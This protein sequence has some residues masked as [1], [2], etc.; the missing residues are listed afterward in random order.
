VDVQGFS[1]DGRGI[2]RWR[3]KTLFVSGA[4]PGETVLCKQSAS[5]GRFNEA[6]TLSVIQASSE[7]VDAPCEFYQR[8]G[9]CDL[10]HLAVDKQLIRKQESVL[11]QLQRLGGLQPE[12]ILP[13]L[14]SESQDYRVRARLAVQWTK[15]GE[16]SLGFR[17]EGS[18]QVVPISQC[19]VLHP[20]ID[21]LLRPLREWLLSI[22]RN[23][24]VTHIELSADVEG[25][26]ILV[27]HTRKLEQVDRD[28]LNILAEKY[29]AVVDLQA[30]NDGV[31]LDLQGATVDP[32]RHYGLPE[33]ELN[34]SFHPS[35]FIQV[36]PELN[37]KM[38]GQ[39]LDLLNLEASD[40]VV[41]LF[42]G[43]GN[44]TL[45]IARRAASVIG[46]EAQ[47]TM[48]ARGRENAAANGMDNA[49][50][51]AANL[52]KPMAPGLLGKGKVDAILL[53]PPRSGAAGAM[54]FIA[55]L[56]PSKLVY[57]S[58]NPSTLARDA[59]ILVEHGYRF[60]TLGIMDMFPH[61]SH[62]ESMALFLLE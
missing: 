3:E 34:L 46:I 15:A 17:G 53:D 23:R 37:K 22:E 21:Q 12:K 60:D 20:S 44:F 42:C 57:V 49:T 31:L 24:P 2:G 47:E 32:R 16:P 56:K 10:Q 25:A 29:S 4:L 33:F 58:C 27:R 62:V 36:N 61:T 55:Q 39:A 52:E 59:K 18:K 7:R 28:S 48:V 40:K 13:A 50:F 51:V 19:T 43:I 8:C 14:A 35:D 1:H 26:C 11:D 54:P 6:K 41:D 5:H 45:P 9:A 30:E 38:V